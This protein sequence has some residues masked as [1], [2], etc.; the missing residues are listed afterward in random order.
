MP[1]KLD[2]LIPTYNRAKIAQIQLVL[3]EKVRKLNREPDLE[4][5]VIVSDNH[6]Q[7]PVEVNENL[8][9]FCT[10]IKPEKHLPTVEEHLRFLLTQS[11]ADYI[12][13]LA[14]EDPPVFE[15]MPALFECLTKEKPDLM[16]LNASGIMS[17]GQFIP[18]RTVASDS[19]RIAD[20]PDFAQR[21]GLLFVAAG[22][23]C[24]VL[25]RDIAQSNIQALDE[26]V[27]IC[28]IYSHVF[29]LLETFWNKR[30]R[31]FEYPC[32]LYKQNLSDVEGSHWIKSANAQG[33][34]Q[35]FFWTLGL[36][37]QMKHLKARVNAP[38][39]FFARI[40]D[41]NWLNRFHLTSQIAQ[42]FFEQLMQE[43][44]SK[45]QCRPSTLEEKLEMVECIVD[46]DPSLVPFFQ[47]FITPPHDA[48]A[49]NFSVTLSCLRDSS[50]NYFEHFLVKKYRDWE[51]YHFDG[52]YRAT[53][54][55][56]AEQKRRIFS[57]I[58]TKSSYN[59][60]A[61][62]NLEQILA[63]IDSTMTKSGDFGNAQFP[64]NNMMI[65][66]RA[67]DAAFSSREVH[68]LKKLIRVY[69]RFKRFLPIS[70]IR[71]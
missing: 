62:A 50:V 29:W 15:N 71:S 48:R 53:W 1:T 52:I 11:S 21:T 66:S 22:I 58:A 5:N 40:I 59:E 24:L 38:E 67:S 51:I 64:F 26:Y 25:K 42:Q 17:D 49:R 34:F 35:Y 32:V 63:K 27:R 37:R 65:S 28:P 3:L 44:S 12:W 61:A 8:K 54:A 30:F 19:S 23:S 6:S 46:F 68:M 13:L 14:D 20:F 9:S 45:S 16:I 7:P 2:I 56:S 31:Y 4:I 18:M 10:L 69:D 41:Q 57:D 33:T 60:L 47:D 36:L 39:D 43:G 70:L 55:A